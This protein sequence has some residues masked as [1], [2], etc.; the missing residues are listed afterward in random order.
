MG[1]LLYSLFLLP[2]FFTIESTR[3]ALWASRATVDGPLSVLS[4]LLTAIALA[5]VWIVLSYSAMA[6]WLPVR[7][8]LWVAG[9]GR[10]GPK[11]QSPAA[12]ARWYES[13]AAR[14]RGETQVEERRG[15]LWR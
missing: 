2:A 14:R 6:A 5:P 7:A 11:K 9:I 8:V 3:T 15:R 12:T 4:V 10:E 1:D 13:K